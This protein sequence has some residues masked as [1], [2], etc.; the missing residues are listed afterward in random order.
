MRAAGTEIR[1][2]LRDVARL[3]GDPLKF[4]QP[5]QPLRDFVVA[6]IFEQPLA[7]AD[8]DIVRIQRALDRK[9]PV[10]LLVALAD[11]DRLGG[12]AVKFLAHLHFDQ[13]ALLLDHD[14]QIEA[15]GELGELAPADRPRAADLVEPDA[16]LVAPDLVD[17]ELVERLTDIEIAFAGG[18]DADLRIAAARS[19][20]VI[21]LLARRNASMA[22]RL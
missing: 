3:R 2:A 5:R 22:S 17:P 9:Q 6:V 21:D 18:D 11:A 19:D 15:G 4:L 1:N 7:D 16:E 8:R 10:A 20:Q 14:D 12:A 13:R